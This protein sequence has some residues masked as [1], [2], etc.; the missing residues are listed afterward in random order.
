MIRGNT[1]YYLVKD[2]L[3]S[4]RLVVN[5]NDGSIA[6]RIDYDEFGRI[7]NDTNPGFQPFGF[8]GGHYDKDTRLVRFG[9]RDYDPETGR[10]T[11]KDPILFKGGDTNLYGYV[12]SDPVNFIDP[13]GLWSFTV[14][15]Y[16]PFT[17]LGGGITFG[18]NPNGSWFGGVWGGGG[19]GGGLSFNP[20]GTSPGY[21]P[22][23]CQNGPSVEAGGYANIGANIGPFGGGVDASGGINIGGQSP[24]YFNPPGHTGGASNTRGVGFGGGVGGQITVVW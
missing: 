1:R 21:K 2:Q 13:L 4:I 14:G 6:Q 22:G 24:G 20:D 9:A 15:G 10:W 7:L 17:G 8:A 23:S 19:F 16:N 18:Q 5:S 11:S 12:M 3:G